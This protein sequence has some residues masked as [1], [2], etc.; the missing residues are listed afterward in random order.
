MC[1]GREKM[2]DKDRPD[3]VRPF[4]GINPWNSEGLVTTR[5]HLPHFEIPLATYFV[6][7]R[8]LKK[9]ELSPVARDV[10]FRTIMD[11]DGDSIDVDA[12]VVMPDHVHAIFRLLG[13]IQL[14]RLLQ[15][16]KGGSAYRINQILQREGSI[17]VEECFDRVV[18]NGNDLE[19]KIAYI[20][21][22]PVKKGLVI[23]ANDYKWLFVKDRAE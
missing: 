10:V 2:P 14:S 8:A 5:R 3:T 16:I 15:R 13:T 9:R 22:N 7:F 20:R 12:I 11:C 19:A 17:W 1:C 4:E 21:Y 6:T 18:R 23:S